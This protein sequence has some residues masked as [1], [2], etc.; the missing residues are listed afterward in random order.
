MRSTSCD[1]LLAVVQTGS[2]RAASRRLGIAQPVITRSIRSLERELGVSLLERSSTGVT[3]TPVGERFV[4]RI[5]GIQTEVQR[6]RAEACQSNGNYSGEVSIALSP[7]TCMILMPAAMAAFNKLHPKAVATV[8][9][10]LFPPIEKK[11][12]NDLHDFW[13]GPIAD[14]ERL[15]TL[16]C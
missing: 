2:L 10:S 11:L 12:A 5:E 13:I 16:L 1:D 14:G 9:Q 8:T 6:A 15:P 7:V 3:L 4:Q